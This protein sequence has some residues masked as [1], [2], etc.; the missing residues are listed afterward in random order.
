MPPRFPIEPMLSLEPVATYYLR[1]AQAYAFVR[2]VLEEAFEAGD[3]QGM[4]RLTADGPVEPDL[5]AELSF[6]ER[7]FLGACVTVMRELGIDPGA[8]DRETVAAAT[9][10][11]WARS[12]GE[13]RDLAQDARTMVPLFFDIE[14]RKTRVWL[15]LG[16][17][18]QPLDIS[19]MRRPRVAIVDA[20][21]RSVSLERVRLPFVPSRKE[22]V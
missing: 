5:D 4:H 10:A 9:Y 8:T 12:C 7:L 2:T 15:F 17:S 1:R 3:L 21:G 16:W 22:L 6:M 20:K 19:F 13:D 18:E 14:R 11:H